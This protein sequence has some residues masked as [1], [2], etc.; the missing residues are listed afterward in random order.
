MRDVFEVCRDRHEEVS[1]DIGTTSEPELVFGRF[2]YLYCKFIDHG[3]DYKTALART[4]DQMDRE[5]REAAPLWM[6]IRNH[7]RYYWRVFI[8][9]FKQWVKIPPFGYTP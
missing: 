3:Y 2:T 1:R 4:M 5:F 9:H 6:R 8:R 7:V